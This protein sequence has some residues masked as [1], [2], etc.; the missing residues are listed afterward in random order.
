MVKVLIQYMSIRLSA[1]LDSYL[2]VSY[3]SAWK[4]VYNQENS[5]LGPEL[6]SKWHKILSL[7]TQFC[8]NMVYWWHEITPFTRLTIQHSPGLPLVA[9]PKSLREVSLHGG[10]LPLGLGSIILYEF[11][12]RLI[13]KVLFCK[14]MTLQ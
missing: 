11:S 6:L 2:I 3:F 7:I 1:I 8:F 4:N 14:K 9:H 10:V 5:S 12:I 13:S